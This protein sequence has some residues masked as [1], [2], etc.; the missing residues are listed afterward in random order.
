MRAFVYFFLDLYNTYIHTHVDVC[1]IS[2]NKMHALLTF[3]SN[4]KSYITYITPLHQ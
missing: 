2:Q 4:S 3:F 1:Q